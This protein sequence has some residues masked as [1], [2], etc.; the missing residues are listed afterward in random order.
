MIESYKYRKIT[1]IAIFILLILVSVPYSKAD[2]YDNKSFIYVDDEA[3]SNWYNSTHV[4][5][6][7]EAINNATT[8]DTIYVY[9]GTYQENI[10]INKTLSL[11]GEDQDNTT[12][13]FGGTGNMIILTSNAITVRNFT[14]ASMASFPSNI[15]LINSNNN[16]ISNNIINNMGK[17]DGTAIK[18]DTCTNNS[19]TNNKI[20]QSGEAIRL[21]Y[22]DDVRIVGCQMTNNHYGIRGWY[23]YNNDILMNNISSNGHG[24]SF[25]D[26]NATISK[27]NISDSVYGIRLSSSQ[28]NIITNTRIVSSSFRGLYLEYSSN[29]NLIYNNYFNNSVNLNNFSLNNQWNISPI[30]GNNIIGGPYIAGNYWNDYTGYDID[31]DGIGDV[32]LPY[33]PGDYY[34][35][36]KPNHVPQANF[37]YSPLESQTY[38]TIYFNDTSEDV[39]GTFEIQNWTWDFGDGNLSY[40]QH[41]THMFTQSGFYD[42]TLTVFDQQG[43]YHSLQK[44]LNVSD[45]KSVV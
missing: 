25:Y 3:P 2:S 37:S 23:S 36:T 34:P 30:M 31:F 41:P 8:G 24:I 38:E 22:S 21:Y 35:L 16:V 6:I 18:L 26:C 15:I 1:S 32:N 19:I 10:V 43:A 42:V 45:R 39:D 11:I 44:T 17:K 7:Q 29:N 40:L 12:I 33:G 14:I 4:R 28:S 27:N 20:S 9:N 5:T 13:S